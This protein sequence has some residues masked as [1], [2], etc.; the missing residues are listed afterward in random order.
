MEFLS[1]EEFS[2]YREEFFSSFE[3]S[4]YSV[5]N[6]LLQQPTAEIVDVNQTDRTMLVSH[7]P[8]DGSEFKTLN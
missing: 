8:K 7:F 3:G 2:K 6:E 1:F 4:L 5:F